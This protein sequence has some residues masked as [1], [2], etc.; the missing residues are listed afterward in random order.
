MKGLKKI[1]N[2]STNLIYR[3]LEKIS[4]VIKDEEH[5][6]LIKS[7]IKIIILIIIYFI[8]GLIAE[9]VIRCGTYIIYH[10]GTSARYILSSIWTATVNFTYF[11]FIIVSLYQLTEI[12]EKDKNFFVLYKNKKKDKELKDKIFLTIDTII[13]ILGT[14][15]L[16]PLFIIDIALLFIFGIMIGY[17]N[18]GIYLYSLFI[19]NIG[20]IIFFTTVIFLIKTLLSPRT[21]KLKKYL[22]IIIFSGLLVATS[23][24]TIM[25]ETANYKTN[26]DLTT[27]FTTSKIKYE[28]KINSNKDYVINNI[29]KDTNLELTIDDDLGS[30][31][32]III[33]HTTT[34]EVSAK[35]KEENNKVRISYDEE[36]DLDFQDFEK[37]FNLG[38]TCIKEKTIY[39]YTLL[40]YAKIEVRVSSDYAKNI[41]FV[42]SKG[43]EYSPYERINK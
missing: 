3:F 18:Q 42:D 36:L 25:L 41:K 39:N 27:D 12:A 31:L 8:C 4:N 6:L 33:T 15:I 1:L 38:L 40:K 21:E 23:S 20:L 34:S 17:L 10:F 29:G 14:I 5:S 32:E 30:Y 22:Y 26:Q 19:T 9:G 2:K 37:I 7:I 35:L 11:L 16:I 24:V 43:V 28:Y 13:K